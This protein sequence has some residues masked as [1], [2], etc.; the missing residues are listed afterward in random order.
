MKKSNA[1]VVMAIFLIIEAILIIYSSKLAFLFVV[2]LALMEIFSYFSIKRLRKDFPWLITP[3]DELP[4]LSDEGLDKFIKSGYDE[5]LGWIRKPNTEKEEIGKEGKTKYHIDSRGSRKNPG[6]EKL[7]TKI[8][9]YGDSFLFARQVN[10]NETC[11]WHLSELTKT[12]ALNF[13]VGNYG[14]DQALLRLKREYPKN[15]TKIVIMGVV[16]STIVRILCVWKHYNEYGNTFGFKPRFVIEKGKLKLIRNFIDEKEKFLEY[17]KYLPQIRKYDYFYKTKFKEDMIRFPYLV[18]ILSDPYRNFRIIFYIL[19]SRLFK[20]KKE[21]DVYPLPMKVIMEI[22]LKLR[23]NLFTK[24]KNALKLMEKVVEEFAAY[25]KKEKFIP[26]FLLMPQKDDLLFIRRKVPYYADFMEKISQ[27]IRTID[28]TDYLIDR[29]DLDAIYSDDNEYG[30]HYS[31]FGNK[32]I[33]KI[34]YDN[35]IGTFI[36]VF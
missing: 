6:H 13:S 24:D 15:K 3:D 31:N 17:Q 12:N 4:T 9:F 26:I 10:D 25:A 19:L 22:N 32:V 28:L 2:F 18:S 34:I 27:K 11:Q 1:V 5:E 20:L 16:P 35:L 29:N 8:S 33:A 23:Y 21:L 36:N 14:L 30:G 7:P